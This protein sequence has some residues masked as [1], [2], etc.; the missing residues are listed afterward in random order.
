MQ[1]PFE[2]PSEKVLG[3]KAFSMYKGCTTLKFLLAIG[4][5]GEP[6]FVSK[7]YLPKG[8]SDVELVKSAENIKGRA[9]KAVLEQWQNTVLFADKGFP[10]QSLLGSHNIDLAMPA[11]L[12][13]KHLSAQEV[14]RS[15]SV[16]SLRF[17][18]FL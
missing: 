14:E 11:F 5:D 16:S 6:F 10:I 1:V 18:F 4:A 8:A 3:S 7:A 2:R 12:L 9:F 17:A 15:K 13:D